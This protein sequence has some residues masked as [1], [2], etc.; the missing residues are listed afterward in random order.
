MGLGEELGGTGSRRGGYAEGRERDVEPRV[1]WGMGRA[2]FV[3]PQSR[4][5]VFSNHT[6]LPLERCCG[7]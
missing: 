1:R 4:S 7:L 2:K 5:R 3:R 6:V